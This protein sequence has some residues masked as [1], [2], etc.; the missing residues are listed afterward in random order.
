MVN[1]K[2]SK[3]QNFHILTKRHFSANFEDALEV[4]KTIPRE[5]AVAQQQSHKRI[6]KRHKRIHR[7]LIGMAHWPC[8]G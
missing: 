3:S 1:M 6:H 4:N 5:A 7:L 2:M 8:L